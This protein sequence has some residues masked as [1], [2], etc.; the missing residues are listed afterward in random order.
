[1]SDGVEPSTRIKSGVFMLVAGVILGVIALPLFSVLGFA[2]L[3]PLLAAPV[4][5]L[6]GLSQMIRGV[7]ER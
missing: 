2:A 1:M 4:L 3:V 5:A 7:R 6:V